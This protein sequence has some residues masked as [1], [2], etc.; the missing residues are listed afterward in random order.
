[1][2]TI[3]SLLISRGEL[4]RIYIGSIRL[5]LWRALHKQVTVA[6]ALY[7]DFSPRQIRGVLRAPDV[8]TKLIDGTEHVVA[9]LGQGTSLFDRQ[10]VFGAGTWTYFEIPAGTE[11]PVGLIITRDRF[12]DKYKATHYSISPNFTMPKTQFVALLDALAAN[13]AAR[14]GSAGNG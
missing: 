14:A 13:A 9:R 2:K 4:D 12:N 3:E 7:P 5:W 6:N 8:E 11:I 10:G 1:M